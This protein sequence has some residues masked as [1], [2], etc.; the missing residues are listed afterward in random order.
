MCPSLTPVETLAR[1]RP[2]FSAALS[3]VD[4]EPIQEALA[5]RRSGES[6]DRSA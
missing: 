4:A 3:H 1:E 2:S 5:R 6:R